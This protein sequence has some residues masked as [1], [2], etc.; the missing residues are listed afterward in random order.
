MK[1]D[2]LVMIEDFVDG[3]EQLAPLASLEAGP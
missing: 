3:E 2:G 1:P